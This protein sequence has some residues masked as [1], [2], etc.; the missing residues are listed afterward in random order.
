MSNYS[1]E[2]FQELQETNNKIL[3]ELENIETQ[4]WDKKKDRIKRYVDNS[5]ILFDAGKIQINNKKSLLLI[6]IKR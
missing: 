6:C 1:A 3:I 5:R 2:D 4:G